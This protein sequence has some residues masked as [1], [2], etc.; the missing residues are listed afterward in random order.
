M[1]NNYR[2]MNLLFEDYFMD[3]LMP[4]I[5]IIQIDKSTCEYPSSNMQ[6][7]WHI[8]LVIIWSLF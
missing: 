3:Y 8:M 1:A 7:I 2:I 5:P 6:I 4:I